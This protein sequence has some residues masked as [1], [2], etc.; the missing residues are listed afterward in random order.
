MS[1]YNKLYSLTMNNLG[2]YYKKIMKPNVALRFMNQALEK[3]TESRQPKSHIASTKL[4]ICAIYSTLKKHD[5]AVE[6]ALS[7]I[8]DLR[9]T[10]QIVKLNAERDRQKDDPEEWN[11][12]CEELGLSPDELNIPE[13]NEAALN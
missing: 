6:I 5:K 7:A 4:N 2:C 10:L 13:K 12:K 11:R 8:N 1:D 9:R 3:E